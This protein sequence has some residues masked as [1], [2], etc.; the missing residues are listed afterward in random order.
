MDYAPYLCVPDALEYRKEKCGGEDAIMAYCIDLAR[1]GGDKVAQ[2]LGT[3]VIGEQSQRECPMAMV[4]LPLDV[5]TGQTEEK[6]RAMGAWIEQCGAQE[7]G[8]FAPIVLHNANLLVRLS[9]QVYLT[10]EDFEQVGKFLALLC[11]RAQG[12]FH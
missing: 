3:E 8:F 12:Q 2:I 7:F 10:L 4:R 11:D 9:A 6:S 1:R 5:V